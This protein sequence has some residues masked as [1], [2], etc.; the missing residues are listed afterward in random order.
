M[1]RNQGGIHYA[2]VDESQRL[3]RIIEILKEAEHPLSAQEIAVQAYDF[4][5]S[6]KVMLNVST[7]IGE[8]RGKDNLDAGYVVSEAKGFRPE[9]GEDP[10]YPWHDGRPRYWLIAA[11]GWVPR[12]RVSAEGALEYVHQGAR[13]QGPGVS[14]TQDPEPLTL[15]PLKC[16]NPNCGR[17]LPADHQGPP[18]CP[19]PEDGCRKAFF[20]SL[21]GTL[22]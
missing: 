21:Q 17:E 6:G 2:L 15:D 11:P 1:P 12:W 20:E 13:G 9:K 4:T 7:N 22:F 5:V 3:A 16:Q 19:G 8:I 14:K 10:L 18:F